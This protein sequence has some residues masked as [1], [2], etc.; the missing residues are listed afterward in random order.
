MLL[1]EIFILNLQMKEFLETLAL[2]GDS[3]N[4]SREK[5]LTRITQLLGEERNQ[6]G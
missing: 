1:K 4:L 5:A 2:L 3:Q 6:D